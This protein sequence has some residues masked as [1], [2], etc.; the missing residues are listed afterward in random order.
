MLN[1]QL[2]PAVAALNFGGLD[3]DSSLPWFQP[4]RK[5]KQ[6]TKMIAETFKILIEAGIPLV[7]EEVYDALDMSMPEEADEVFGTI[8]N[9]TSILQN[10]GSAEPS[11]EIRRMLAKLPLDAREYF[12]ARLLND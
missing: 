9:P 12:M 10:P 6:D 8:Q 2:I 11:P 5:S 3:E 7:K 4:T 1:E